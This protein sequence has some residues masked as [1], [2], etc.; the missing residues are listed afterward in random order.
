MSL[1]GGRYRQLLSRVA[2]LEALV[3][4]PR[5]KWVQVILDEKAGDTE[6]IVM[7]RWIAENQPHPEAK[8]R[9]LFWVIV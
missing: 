9:W 4:A 8:I 5:P 1:S 3:P 7:A 6:E 2:A